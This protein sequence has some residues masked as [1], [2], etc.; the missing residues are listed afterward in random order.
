MTTSAGQHPDPASP[1][2]R[3]PGLTDRVRTRQGRA[4]HEPEPC[5]PATQPRVKRD[6]AAAEHM[7]ERDVLGVVGLG[8]AELRGH[9]PRID[10]SDS[11][12]MRTIGA[13]NTR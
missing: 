4:D 1:S 13:A 6:E 11:G 5:G 10:C 3:P 8:P 9:G 2:T 12:S 7:S